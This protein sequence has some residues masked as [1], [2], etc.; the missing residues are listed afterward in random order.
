VDERIKFQQ[1]EP[2][3]V[4]IAQTAGHQRRIEH[5]QRRI[6]RRDDRLA[7]ADCAGGGNRSTPR[8]QQPPWLAWIAGRARAAGAGIVGFGTGIAIARL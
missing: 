5:E 4:G 2:R 3:Q 7:L 8:S 1:I 6:G